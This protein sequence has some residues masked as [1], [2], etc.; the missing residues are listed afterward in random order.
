MKDESLKVIPGKYSDMAIRSID[1]LPSPSSRHSPEIAAGYAK[2]GPARGGTGLHHL[3]PLRLRPLPIEVG[4][5]SPDDGERLGQG[6]A[7]RAEGVVVGSR[8]QERGV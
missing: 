3:L 6:F 2:A 8:R 4:G 1:F 5:T 7:V